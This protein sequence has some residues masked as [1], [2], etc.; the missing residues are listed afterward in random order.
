MRKGSSPDQ[1][2]GIEIGWEWKPTWIAQEPHNYQLFPN[3]ELKEL[4]VGA[5]NHHLQRPHLP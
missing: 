2:R 1:E 4:V 3:R 5:S